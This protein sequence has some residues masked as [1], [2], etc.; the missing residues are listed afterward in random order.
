MGEFL[1]ET[2]F[3]VMFSH[4]LSLEG[5]RERERERERD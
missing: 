2:F 1:Q 4:G 3:L 5:E